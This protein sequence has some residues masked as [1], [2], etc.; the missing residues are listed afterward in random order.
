MLFQMSLR[1]SSETALLFM[2]VRNW[3]EWVRSDADETS[4]NAVLIPER[5][6]GSASSAL[7]RSRHQRGFTLRRRRRWSRREQQPLPMILEWFENTKLILHY[8][9]WVLH[10]NPEG[11]IISLGNLDSSL[12]TGCW[13]MLSS[14][15]DEH[16][17]VQFRNP[18]KSWLFWA[19]WINWLGFNC[20]TLLE[21]RQ[22]EDDAAGDIGRYVRGWS[23]NRELMSGE[24]IILPAKWIWRAF[25]FTL[26][27]N[28]AIESDWM[29]A[30]KSHHNSDI[31]SPESRRR[32]GC[33]L[34]PE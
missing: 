20:E 3:S 15:R 26:V 25:P 23:A 10:C 33:R 18:I 31:L 22:V 21:S 27:L 17:Q 2:V 34:V 24:P 7:I 1:V 14:W 16:H 30:V 12:H 29:N 13:G 32:P 28:V 6:Q 4:S 19:L 9:L 5:F 8:N 11:G